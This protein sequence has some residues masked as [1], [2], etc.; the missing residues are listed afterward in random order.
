M[1][2]VI[3]LGGLGN[4]GRN[5]AVLEYN[6]RI[7]ILDCGVMFPKDEEPGVDRILPDF[8]YLEGRWNDIE[9]VALTHGHEDHIGGIPDLLKNREN[10]P[11]IGSQFTLALV[12]NKTE[13][14]HQNAQFIEVKEGDTYTLP[15]FKLEFIAV[16]HSIPDALAI[17]VTCPDGTIL[18]TGDIKLDQTPIDRRI[19]DLNHFSKIAAKG[20]DL[21]M[22]DSTNA[23]MPG[24]V[25]TERGIEKELDFIF[26][27]ATKK[28]VVTSF[29][30][31]IHRIQQIITVA[32]KHNRY[33]CFDGRSM[34][35]TIPLARELGL[36]SYDPSMIVSSKNI[37][38]YPDH[39][40]VIISTGSQGE[41]MAAL[42]RI[43]KGN[44][45]KITINED[46]VIIFASSIIPGNEKSIFK[47]MNQLALL[48]AIIYDSHNSKIHVSGHAAST[49]LLYLYNII[50]PKNV[51]PIHGEPMH[52]IANR[53]LA[54]STGIP[55]RNVMKGLDGVVINLKNGQ[56][57]VIDQLPNTMVKVLG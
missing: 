6:R 28:I 54:E 32:R 49:E 34:Q 52:L 3:P 16:N 21:L 56:A 38:D 14:A 30:S 22:I 10:I 24:V 36:I 1:V 44:H 47:I 26:S 20:V 23:T 40:I 50:K 7:L 11:I 15:S 55:H 43:A 4:I 46:D 48:G 2:R 12:K 53:K 5:M 25:P 35:K 42:S 13:E 18:N 37:G 33:V 39:R 27:S 9:A 51:L 31:H 29:A 57:Q 19:T 41:P 17:Y 8:G 45:P